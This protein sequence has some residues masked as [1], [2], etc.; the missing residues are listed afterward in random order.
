MAPSNRIKSTRYTVLTFLPIVLFLQFKKVVV[1]FYTFNT[2]LNGIPNVSVNSPVQSGAPL[3]F[4]IL[5]SMAKEAYLE[6][7]RY[8]EDRRVNEQPCKII[9][10][11]INS[12]E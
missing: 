7:K 4:V 1:C 12:S 11:V 10:N 6:C 3:L 5:V 8:R 2:I 9:K